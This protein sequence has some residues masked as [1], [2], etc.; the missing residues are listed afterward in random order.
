MS[1]AIGRGDVWHVDVRQ[2]ICGYERFNSNRI[3]NTVWLAHVTPCA[4]WW[5]M[6]LSRL[7]MCGMVRKKFRGCCSI[8]V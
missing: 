7:V 5:R 8:Q 2:G 6:V 4:I 3:Q 1:G